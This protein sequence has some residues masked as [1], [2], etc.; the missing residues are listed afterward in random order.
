M[1]GMCSA[2]VGM[3]SISYKFSYKQYLEFQTEKL[4]IIIIIIIG[5][6]FIIVIIIVITIVMPQTSYTAPVGLHSRLP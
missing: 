5:A 3:T 1:L 2:S 6:I 4:I